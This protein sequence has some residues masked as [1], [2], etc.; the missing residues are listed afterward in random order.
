[1]FSSSLLGSFKTFR[2][3]GELEIHGMLGP[4]PR[5]PSYGMPWR[6]GVLREVHSNRLGNQTPEIETLFNIIPF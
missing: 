3:G 4:K 6:H 5:W 1:M 2:L